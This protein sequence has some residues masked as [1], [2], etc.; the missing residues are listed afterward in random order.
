MFN[1]SKQKNAAQPELAIT[2]EQFDQLKCVHCGGAHLRAC[3][4]VKRMSF[5]TAGKIVE[6]EFW[7]ENEWS[8]DN[9]I[10][11]E[12]ILEEDEDEQDH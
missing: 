1:R 9:V 12:D 11:P 7:R 3:P 2:P 4:R 6:V 10:W 5:D 8:D